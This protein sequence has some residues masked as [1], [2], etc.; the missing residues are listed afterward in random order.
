[1]VTHF[2]VPV[3]GSELSEG[4]LQA[5]INLAQR[6]D[7]RMTVFYA[8]PTAGAYAYAKVPLFVAT[9]E[10]HGKTLQEIHQLIARSAAT[11]L[12]GLVARVHQAGDPHGSIQV[13][14]ECVE[15]DEPHRAILDAAHRLGC[16]LIVMASHGRRGVGALLLGS[17]TQKVLTHSTLPV[18]VWPPRV[19]AA[20]PSN[21]ERKTADS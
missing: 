7:A 12:K 16:D 11:Y 2:M 4:A 19:P 9:A 17:E 3:D 8:L 5:S 10:L 15:S 1:M 14:S 6:L 21:T 20:I 18:L 13:A